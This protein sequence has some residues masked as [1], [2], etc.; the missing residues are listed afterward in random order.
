MGPSDSTRRSQEPE[1]PD[2]DGRK[3]NHR[4][5]PREKSWRGGSWRPLGPRRLVEMRVLEERGR[6]AE[7]I[8]GNPE[9]GTA[10]GTA[11]GVEG[12]LGLGELSTQPRAGEPAALASVGR[13]SWLGARLLKL[14]SSWEK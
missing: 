3:Y 6:T 13:Q 5:I 1:E 14:G 10:G 2:G 8:K 11:R 7:R 9:R 12:G 4:E